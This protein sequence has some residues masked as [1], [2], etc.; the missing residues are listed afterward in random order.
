MAL[1]KNECRQITRDPVIMR[2]SLVFLRTLYSSP[3]Y[4]IL[5]VPDIVRTEQRT[6][7]F[8]MVYNSGCNET[9]EPLTNNE[10]AVLNW[11]SRR[12]KTGV[13][14]CN[15]LLEIFV[16]LF[17][18]FAGSLYPRLYGAAAVFSSSRAQECSIGRGLAK[19]TNE[20]GS[21]GREG[22]Y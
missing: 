2:S 7:V 21:M 15:H 8:H 9:T 12:V 1:F 5:C 16:T 6:Y 13:R 11:P 4:L 17:S 3:I 14:C 19:R 10:V 22:G 20:R 18:S